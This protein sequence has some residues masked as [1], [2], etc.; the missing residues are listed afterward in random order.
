[1]DLD[2][3][4]P[5]IPIMTGCSD[6]KIRMTSC[7]I[8]PVYIKDNLSVMSVSFFLEKDESAVIWRGPKKNGLIKQFLRDVEWDQLEFLVIDTPPGTSDE[9]LTIASCLKHPSGPSPFP[10]TFAIIVTTPQV[11]YKKEEHSMLTNFFVGN[12]TAGCTQ[13]N[14][15]L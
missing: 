15:L 12:C 7:G 4:G 5:S 3:C 13:R 2:I 6:E 9:H 10:N 14:R 8:L 11:S 1:M